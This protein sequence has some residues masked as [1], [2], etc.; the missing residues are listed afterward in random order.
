MLA[1]VSVGVCS[2]R[3]TQD[4]QGE[5][6]KLKAKC[7]GAAAGLLGSHFL[8]PC[9]GKGGSGAGGGGQ[10]DSRVSRFLGSCGRGRKTAWVAAPSGPARDGGQHR[11][12]NSPEVAGEPA[13]RG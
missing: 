9:G 10:L 7:P 11:L 4:E 12:W 1:W 5:Q 3:E 2:T 13:T 8:G 6:V